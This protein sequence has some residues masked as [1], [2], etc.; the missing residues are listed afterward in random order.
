MGQA[1]EAAGHIIAIERERDEHWYT[2]SAFYAV[3][4]IS[5]WDSTT[6]R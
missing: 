2:F 6:Y 1:H 5:P 3:Q 4:D